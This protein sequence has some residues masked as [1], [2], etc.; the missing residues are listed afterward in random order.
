LSKRALAALVAVLAIAA[1]VA[2][3]GG[4]S[5]S[6]SSGGD[7]GGDTTAQSSGPAPT[8]AQFVKEADAICTKSDTALNS[9]IESYAKENGIPSNKEPSKDQQVEIYEAVVLP[10]VSQQSDEIGEL[11]PPEGDEETIE[12][13]VSSL[14]EGVEEAEA[15]PQQL[16]EGKNPLADATSQAKAYGMTVCGQG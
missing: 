16:V 3:C 2:G 7:T 11:T 5:D 14:S 9:E 13:L 12:E 15:D 4:G 6:T 8:K 1:A 10:N